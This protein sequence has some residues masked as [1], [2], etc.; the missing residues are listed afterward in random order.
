MVNDRAQTWSESNLEGTR[1][2]LDMWLPR[3][4]PIGYIPQVERTYALFEGGAGYG[5]M[6]EHG[7]A[8]AESTCPARFASK[9]WGH[10]GN[11]LLD[12][13]ELSK[14]ALERSKTA[15]EAIIVMGTM[16]EKYG[17]YGAEWDGDGRY[18]ESGESLMVADGTEAWVFHITPDDTGKSAVWAAQ[19]VPDNGVAV[20]ANAFI[21]REIDSADNATFLRSTNLYK[22]AHRSGAWEPARD[23]KHVDFAKVFGLLRDPP[24]NSYYTIRTWR[25]FTIANPDL[26]KTLNPHPN[27][28]MDGYPFSVSPKRKLSRDDMFRIYRDHFEG[29]QFDLTK[30]EAAGPYGDPDRYDVTE[31]G[32]WT[33]PVVGYG[34]FGRAISMF[35][36]SYTSIAKSRADA[37]ALTRA[38]LYVALQQASSS[39]FVPLYVSMREVP[40]MLMRGSLFRYTNESMFWAVTTVSNWVHRYYSWAVRDLEEF[41]RRLEKYDPKDIEDFV[42]RLSQNGQVTTAQMTLEKYCRDIAERVHREYLELFPLMVSK[43]HDGYVRENEEGDKVRMRSMFYPEWWLVRVGFY[44]ARETGGSYGRRYEMERRLNR[45]I[46]VLPERESLREDHRLA[47]YGFVMG[48]IV[49]ALLM[50]M[51]LAL[52][53]GSKSR[54]ESRALGYQRIG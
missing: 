36:S 43:F 45:R 44:S 32:N 20:V 23:G 35:R 10:G 7:V 17:Y 54:Y 6:N 8:M 52:A 4:K 42:M 46:S 49:G 38:L 14:I 39:V 15:R 26:L 50:G 37:P 25:V 12:V 51:A 27:N 34:E 40:R 11:A 21:I 22:V 2:Q 47:R 53:W 13:G 24:Q 29:T 31:E 5:L 3:A 41:Q 9:P 1:R 28:Y 48:M 16:A 19:R 30:G 18:E 33:R